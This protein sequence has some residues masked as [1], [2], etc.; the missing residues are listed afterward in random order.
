MARYLVFP[1]LHGSRLDVGVAA[2]SGLPR[3]RVRA[4]AQAGEVWIN[5]SPTRVLSHTLQTGDVVDVIAHGRTLRE[6]AEPPVRL[7]LLHR[8]GFLV[9]VDK[10]AGLATQSPRRRRVG[11]FTVHELITLQL[12]FELGQRPDLTLVHRLDRITTGVLIFAAHRDASRALTTA[13]HGA[14]VDKRYLAVVSGSVRRAAFSVDAPIARDPL[15][16]GRYRVDR[17][18]RPARSEVTVVSQSHGVALVEVRPLSGRTHQVRV[19][20]AEAGIPVA[21]DRLYGGSAG[22]P[23]PFLHAW[24]LS[25][26]HP[27]SHERLRLEA[28]LPDDMVAHLARMGLAFD[29]RAP[30]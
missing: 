24:R 20:L 21:G 22:A 18:G 9:A 6:P 14:A 25:L 10:P 1:E 12:A 16:P 3:R 7:T 27:A 19:H 4:D 28:P 29:P 23:R 11:E 13:W 17:R 30:S 15:A 26:P 5:G 8:D 2:L